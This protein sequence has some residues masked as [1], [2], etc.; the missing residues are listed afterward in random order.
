MK[1]GFSLVEVM[2]IFTVLSVI[3]AASIPMIS[4]KAN[5]IQNKVSHGVYRCIQTN[6]GLVEELYSGTRRVKFS[7]NANKCTF[8]VPQAAQYKVD[9]YSAGSGG[10]LF[11][12]VNSQRDDSR[13]HTYT[14]AGRI[15][16][17]EEDPILKP[18]DSELAK[19]FNGKVVVRSA[20]TGDAGNGGNADLTYESPYEASCGIEVGER[21]ALYEEEIERLTK[22]RNVL[23]NLLN[24][25]GFVDK[26]TVVKNIKN[27]SPSGYG[28]SVDLA[29]SYNLSLAYTR[30]EIMYDIGYDAPHEYQL[31]PSP[32]YPISYVFSSVFV[33]PPYCSQ[34][35]SY[36]LY[37]KDSYNSQVRHFYEAFDK[38]VFYGSKCDSVNG[39]S[40]NDYYS[41]W[42]SLIENNVIYTSD[43]LRD[44][45][46]Y[47][48]SREYYKF[49]RAVRTYAVAVEKIYSSASTQNNAAIDNALET[50]D[51][52]ATEA[53][54]EKLQT[55]LNK[56]KSEL[57][58]QL[59]ISTKARKNAELA[60]LKKYYKD[61][62][63]GVVF[64]VK[65][66]SNTT[67]KIKNYIKTL[68]D[69][70]QGG[71]YRHRYNV[72]YNSN[73]GGFFAFYFI[74]DVIDNIIDE[75]NAN[76]DLNGVKKEIEDIIKEYDDQINALRS[77][78]VSDS[79]LKNNKYS[80][81]PFTSLY[82]DSKLVV[83]SNVRKQVAEFC[84]MVFKNYYKLA[85]AKRGRTITAADTIR[86]DEK[87]VANFGGDGGKG[88]YSRIKI[89]INYKPS[90]SGNTTSFADYAKNLLSVN[91]KGYYPVYC[92]DAMGRYCSPSSTA[93]VFS[94]GTD[95]TANYKNRE[96]KSLFEVVTQIALKGYEL[97]S[98]AVTKLATLPHDQNV[99]DLEEPRQAEDECDPV[100]YPFG[101]LPVWCTE[102]YIKVDSDSKNGKF[103]PTK[104]Q[105]R[106]CDKRVFDDY[107][108][109]LEYMEEHC[110]CKSLEYAQTHPDECDLNPHP[111]H[112]DPITS[113]DKR[114]LK[115]TN[116]TSLTYP[117]IGWHISGVTTP[118]M[119]I[120]TMPTGG[121]RKK[122]Y[123]DETNEQKQYT[124]VVN[125]EVL[126]NMY[127]VYSNYI[128][129]KN[130]ANSIGETTPK[131]GE[132]IHHNTYATFPDNNGKYIE[133]IDFVEPNQTGT[134]PANME[135]NLH[136]IPTDLPIWQEPKLVINSTLWTKRYE[137]GAPGKTGNS[138]SFTAT[139][140][141]KECTFQV[142]SRGKVYAKTGDST[143]D[144]ATMAELEALLTT[145]MEC[146]DRENK[147]VFSHSVDGNAYT[148]GTR[149]SPKTFKWSE[150]LETVTKSFKAELAEGA[151]K[152]TW[153]RT[154]MWAKIFQFMTVKETNE[155]D[156]TSKGVGQAGTGTTLIDR[157]VARRGLY[158]AT[159]YYMMQYLR[160]D[161]AET[162]LPA[163]GIQYTDDTVT[164]LRRIPRIVSTSEVDKKIATE[165]HSLQ[166]GN[167]SGFNCYGV[168]DPSDENVSS[169]TMV[170]TQDSPIVQ[171]GL[172]DL[173][174]EKGGG[175]A[176]V[177][178]W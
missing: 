16:N 57:S 24:D 89:K 20:Y 114:L 98:K 108:E 158:E 164:G 117:Y 25:L 68:P 64:E 86:F 59:N 78:G 36:D 35:Y 159:T 123:V 121:E 160:E 140:L 26:E 156:L 72:I 177:I 77:E 46:N 150:E 28:Y 107:N 2:I 1:K 33:E 80:K 58:G 48:T 166:E 153:K 13:V 74:R 82:S 12:K 157:C 30:D 152:H 151:Q 87:R 23:K 135:A 54:K 174:I 31:Y 104:P 103:D 96:N 29:T 84:N 173:I 52:Y 15:D 119:P 106:S 133:I 129:G 47:G 163:N 60:I 162:K 132:N 145:S 167:Q 62:T 38:A 155:Y 90:K 3:L 83:N 19:M 99:A 134:T 126:E 102:R 112:D 50:I 41:D 40:L 161:Q 92:S 149:P 6:N 75:Y 81:V 115:T 53:E 172:M 93:P 4:K 111:T 66:S 51:R 171:K 42:S 105:Y 168:E 32:Y 17:G 70:K 116:G 138:I 165:R 144:R 130:Y 76:L 170:I 44:V 43:Y 7:P 131:N 100:N 85:S 95:I 124:P 175:G 71:G 67:T 176:V 65:T 55:I 148:D 113:G 8:K 178:T 39:I 18:N 101:V 118:I 45:N 143:K 137:L 56:I 110:S 9:M 169:A 97:F 127:S 94:N 154:S 11:A 125:G 22:I 14:M 73:K 5:P 63:E 21:N 27:P 88:V 120:K 142:A 91:T 147:V 37:P 10:T 34:F 109:F 122:I 128:F 61:A 139:D 146:K 79:Y 136:N 69:S 141:G 49:P